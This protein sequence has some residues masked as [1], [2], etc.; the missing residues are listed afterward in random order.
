MKISV[1]VP[2]FNCEAYLPACIDS[3][4]MQTYSD[5][6]IILVDDGSTDRSSEICDQYMLQDSR[7]RVFHQE[8]QGVSSARNQGLQAATGELIS[9]IDSDDTLEPD[10]YELL[11]SN[12]EKYNA[13]ISHC[14]FNRIEGNNIR[15]IYGTEQ[16]AVHNREQALKCLIAGHS[17]TGSLWNKLYKKEILHGLAFREDLKINEDILFNFEVFRRAKK[18]VFSDYAKYNYLV[19]ENGSACAATASEK[20]M[21]DSVIVN[22]YMYNELSASNLADVAA[23]RYLRCMSGYYRYCTSYKKAECKSVATE[24]WEIAKKNKALGL[25]MNTTV[26]LIHYCPWLYHLVYFMYNKIR[27]PKWEV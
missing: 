10:M 9:F 25:R 20:K 17:F 11:V 22:Q 18:T 4:L 24:M 26:R 14:G 21:R 19:R 13:E 2:V 8:N 5:L 23:E 6:Q 16:T 27:K 12:M 1:I 15:P 3:I 7:V